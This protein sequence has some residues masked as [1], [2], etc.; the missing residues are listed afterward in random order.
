MMNK[1]I[2]T[3]RVIG[4]DRAPSISGLLLCILFQ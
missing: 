2:K 4:R 1:F 3:K